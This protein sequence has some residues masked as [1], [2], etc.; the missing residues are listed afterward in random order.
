MNMGKTMKITSPGMDAEGAETRCRTKIGIGRFTLIEL[1]VARHTKLA[2]RRRSTIRTRFTLIELLV[3]I[4]IISILAAML[5]PAL[6]KARD[7]AKTSIC[8]NNLKQLYTGGVLGYAD[9]YGDWLPPPR[10]TT[11]YDGSY[12]NYYFGRI[13]KDYL[14][15]KFASK[16]GPYICP[17]EKTL[18]TVST[19]DVWAPW[20]YSVCRANYL[21]G[22]GDTPPFKP[23]YKIGKVRYPP[24]SSLMIDTLP[25]MW[26]Y[27][28]GNYYAGDYWPMNAWA[29]RHN[30]GLNALFVDGHIEY[31]SLR[32]MPI[33]AGN[34]AD[35]MMIWKKPS[36]DP[37]WWQ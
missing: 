19:N 9:D 4:A 29:P 13:F 5:L 22:A 17:E 36:I 33:A 31:R 18:P 21:Y 10:L 3:V 2:A 12:G 32:S 27:A 14:N 6:K 28:G 16:T 1:L 24:V 25:T 8:A 34:D 35:V 15:V 20:T 30:S 26:C 37:D 7:V 23:R 11:A